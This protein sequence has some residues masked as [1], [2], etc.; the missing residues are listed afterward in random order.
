MG[1]K[2]RRKEK[3][4]AARASAKAFKAAAYSN[5]DKSWKEALEFRY[6]TD[7]TPSSRKVLAGS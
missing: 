6:L 3:R 7:P 5:R 1:K 2:K 4:D